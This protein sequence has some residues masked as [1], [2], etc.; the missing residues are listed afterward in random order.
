ME[1]QEPVLETFETGHSSGFGSIKQKAECANLFSVLQTCR[2]R[3]VDAKIFSALRNMYLSKKT[4]IPPAGNI[5]YILIYYIIISLSLQLILAHT[6]FW[7]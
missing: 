6:S 7:T 1:N 3:V 4:P 2:C 5:I